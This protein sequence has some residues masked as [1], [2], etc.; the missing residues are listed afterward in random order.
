MPVPTLPSI[1]LVKAAP[2]QL[3]VLI[4]GART[5]PDGLTL[6]GLPDALAKT[7]GKGFGGP[8]AFAAALGVTGKLEQTTVLPGDGVRVVV[9]G[10]GE[11]DSDDYDLRRAAG[12]AVRTAAG[13]AGSDPLDLVLALPSSDPAD[14]RAIAEGALLGAYTFRPISANEKPAAV[15]SISLV[16]SG[17]GAA[18]AVTEA[19]TLATG[20]ARAREWVNT[21]AN[22]LYPETFAAEAK[23]LAKGAKLTVDVLD[24]KQLAA[25][26]YGGLTAVGGGSARGPRLIRVA[27]SPRGATQTLALVGKGITFDSGGLDLKPV[28]G[29]YTMKCDMA[30]AAAVLA[31]VRTIADLGLKVNVIAYAACAENMP[32]GSSYRPSDVLT[33]YGGKTVEN[34]NTDAEGRLVMADALARATEDKPTALVDVATLTGA[35]VVGLGDTVAAVLSPEE[36]LVDAVMD[37]ADEA[38]ELFWPLPITEEARGKLTDSQVADV[39]STGDRAGGALTAAA[40]LE[41]FVGETPWA[42]LDIAGPAFVTGGAKA[43]IG[44][45]GTGFGVTTLVE[46]ARSMAD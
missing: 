23:E 6:L 7:F 44:T 39:K 5:G 33:I 25:G 29:M 24:D 10:L 22:L 21:P 30:G 46:L 9:V 32:S 2:K 36:N 35:A 20:V 4:I 42:H 12:V 26:G 17:R 38:G 27:Y 11:E 40:F 16:G 13:L 28:E 41:H 8:Q 45:G 3:D 31:A 34:G 19:T 1:E 15:A 18:E 37:A 14:I 43:H